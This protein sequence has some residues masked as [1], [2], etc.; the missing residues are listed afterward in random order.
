MLFPAICDELGECQEITETL[1]ERRGK[2]VQ[3]LNPLVSWQVMHLRQAASGKGEKTGKPFGETC[4]CQV[5]PDSWGAYASYATDPRYDQRCDTAMHR[6]QFCA[7]QNSEPPIFEEW[8]VWSVMW[9]KRCTSS[10]W[11][12]VLSPI[13]K[14]GYK[15]PWS[16]S[17]LNG[18]S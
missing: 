4:E 1:Q 6:C 10:F 11:E 5:V 14:K 7:I 12:L 15:N 8:S 3:E 16:M 2:S 18:C 13:E 17:Q 9:K